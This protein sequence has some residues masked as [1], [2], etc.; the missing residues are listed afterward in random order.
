M[1][2]DEPSSGATSLVLATSEQ[3][4]TEKALIR[5][6]E[7]PELKNIQARLR[8]ELAVTSRGRTKDGAARLD[9]AIAY[10]K[11]SMEK[12]NELERR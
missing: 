11:K 4:E 1:S 6:L 5:L 7:E 2:I 3:I 10:C 8:T 12:I 9:E